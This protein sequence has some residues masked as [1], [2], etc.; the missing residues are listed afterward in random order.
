MTN[1]KKI[2]L[3][4]TAEDKEFFDQLFTETVA[5]AIYTSE[6]SLYDADYVLLPQ[7]DVIALRESRNFIQAILGYS[8]VLLNELN[9]ELNDLQREDVE[10]ILEYAKKTRVVFDKFFDIVPIYSSWTPHLEPVHISD[11]M[12]SVVSIFKDH[13]KSLILSITIPDDLPP[14]SAEKYRVRGYI[15]L[16]IFNQIYNYAL[17]DSHIRIDARE[18]ENFVAM[19]FSLPDFTYDIK[20]IFRRYTPNGETNQLFVAK[21]LIESYGGEFWF[22]NTTPDPTIY[23]VL[24][25]FSVEN[26]SDD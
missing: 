17:K 25:T 23:F 1:K 26:S 11:E 21:Q 5:E 3:N 18:I 2:L 19:T 4:V 8:S 20:E 14:V 9:G 7:R 22:E 24:P 16:P 12:I 15:L 6:I 10:S 13:E